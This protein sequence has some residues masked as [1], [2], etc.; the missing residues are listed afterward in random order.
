MKSPVQGGC[1]CGEIRYECQGESVFVINCHCRDCQR[2]SGGAMATT[3]FFPRDNFKLLRGTSKSCV[4]TA[5]SGNLIA[6]HFCGTC[7]SPLFTDAKGY[8]DIWGVKIA[9]LDD[10]SL[11]APGMHI[12]TDSAQPWDHFNDQLP[13]FPKAPPVA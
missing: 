10:P 6:R 8:P 11:V 7:G 2:A 5:D 9:S 4:F 3:V 12:W 13:S 1:A